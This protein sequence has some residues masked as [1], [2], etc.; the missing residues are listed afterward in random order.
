MIDRYITQKGL[1][2]RVEGLGALGTRVWV[3]SKNLTMPFPAEVIRRG[4]DRWIFQDALIQNAFGFL[5]TDQREFLM[6]GMTPE[7][8]AA[9][10]PP[11]D[12]GV[13][14]HGYANCC[15]ACNPDGPLGDGL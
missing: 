7:E 6:T 9:L 8:W 14:E 5:N 15:R 3:G 12:D 4:L 11:E 10:F 2:V 13:C 1:T